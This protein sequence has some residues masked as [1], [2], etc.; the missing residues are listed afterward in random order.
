MSALASRAAVAPRWTR[1][2]GTGRCP[3]TAVKVF[4]NIARRGAAARA[5][6]RS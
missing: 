4:P 3:A 1:R 5:D 2:A 6:S